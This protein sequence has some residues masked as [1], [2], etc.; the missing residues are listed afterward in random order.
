MINEGEAGDDLDLGALTGGGG[1]GGRESC[2]GIGQR[3]T[4][5]TELCSDKPRPLI[6]CIVELHNSVWWQPGLFR[7]GVDH[8]GVYSGIFM[9]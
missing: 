4:A 5:T 7:V 3:P 9:G 1:E 8:L 2:E 6:R